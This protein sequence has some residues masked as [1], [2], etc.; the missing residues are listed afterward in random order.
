MQ[1][2][3][4][5]RVT[6]YWI[7]DPGTRTIEIHCLGDGAYVLQQT[8]SGAEPVVSPVVPGLTF[9]ADSIFPE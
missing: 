6:K 4:R 1:M 8:K 3:A 5:Y 2:F 9:R 7:V